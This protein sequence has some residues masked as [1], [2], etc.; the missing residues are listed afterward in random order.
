MVK[1]RNKDGGTHHAAFCQEKSA[2]HDVSP[3]TEAE[4]EERSAEHASLSSG[5]I[6]IGDN[7]YIQSMMSFH[8]TA[9]ISW[10]AP[11]KEKM[12]RL[13]MESFPLEALHGGD[14]RH[15][16]EKQTGGQLRGRGGAPVSAPSLISR[17]LWETIAL[18]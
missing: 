17:V 18:A 10:W 3:R 12:Q 13:R 6:K 1:N 7:Y 4:A 14:L 16:T 8:S 15:L 5:H 9:L 2:R 11:R